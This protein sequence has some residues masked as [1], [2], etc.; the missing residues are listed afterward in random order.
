M[1]TATSSDR[2]VRFLMDTKGNQLIAWEELTT[3]DIVIVP[4]F[5][6]TVENQ[7]KL[8]ELGNQLLCLRHNLPFCGKGLE[9]GGS[10]R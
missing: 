5:G 6:T 3:E 4:A 7:N 2:G 10:D 1:L 8:A 9:P